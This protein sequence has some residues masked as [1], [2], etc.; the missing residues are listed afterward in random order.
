MS[1][2]I[3]VIK[4]SGLG[5][6]HTTT[7][8]NRSTKRWC[9]IIGSLTVLSLLGLMLLLRSQ[10]PTYHP[11]LSER[12]AWATFDASM[13]SYKT[14]HRQGLDDLNKQRRVRTL[15]VL[16]AD[17]MCGGYGDQM[18]RVHFFFLMALMSNRVF[19]IYWG[20]FYRKATRHLEPNQ[21]DWNVTNTSSVGMC[22]DGQLLCS[23]AKRYP[24][25]SS[26]AWST[27]KYEEFGEVLFGNEQHVIVH[28]NVFINPMLICDDS[29]MDTGRLITEGL[30]KLGIRAILARGRNQQVYYTQ[31]SLW[32][33]VVLRIIGDM[34]RFTV[35]ASDPWV[36]LNHAIF[37]YLF[38]F[39]EEILDHVNNVKKVLG[40]NQQPYLAL[41]LRTG[42][43]GTAAEEKWN[44]LWSLKNWKLFEDESAW[45]CILGY[46]HRLADT[47]IGPNAP[48]YLATDS[49]V[50]KEWA[51]RVYGSRIR[52]ASFVPFHFAGG[53]HNQDEKSVWVDF[54][55]LSG[56]QVLVHGDSSY[57]INAA[58]LMPIPI[59]R[60]SWTSHSRTKGCL[61]SHIGNNVTCMC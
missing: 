32:Y 6:D 12:E 9:A 42:F 39:R 50:T 21:I 17:Q 4:R 11:Q 24:S 40:I 23:H 15:T 52:T 61:A 20:D 31:S 57:A 22:A 49:T 7:Q 2:C 58:F 30:E 28:G 16:C 46:C 44:Y 3:L 43:K 25:T 8:M 5:R 47:L 14:L 13:K 38:K 48:I 34:G 26:F 54:L 41:H 60:Q 45:S 53:S 10:K 19:T 37:N 33:S 18:Y 56:A 55:I 35:E 59:T 36:H 1:V 27:S 51:V 29:L